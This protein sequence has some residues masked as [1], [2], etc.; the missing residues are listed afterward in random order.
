MQCYAGASVRA[1]RYSSARLSACGC[2]KHVDDAEEDTAHFDSC[3]I[4]A[5]AMRG[6]VQT[7]PVRANDV[8]KTDACAAVASARARRN[9]TWTMSVL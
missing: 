1:Q 9:G 3:A 2:S 7:V 4:A 5:K 6:A 8:A